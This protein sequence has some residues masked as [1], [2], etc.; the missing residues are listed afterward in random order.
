LL[1]TIVGQLQEK[2]RDKDGEEEK[3]KRIKKRAGNR[4]EEKRIQGVKRPKRVSNH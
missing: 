2:G 4:R 1:G 3:G